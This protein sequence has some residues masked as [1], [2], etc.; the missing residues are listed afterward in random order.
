MRIK[1]I[2]FTFIFAISI[3]FVPA[4]V[5]DVYAGTAV[6]GT[7]RFN[8][9]VSDM[10]DCLDTGR[11]SQDGQAR[12]PQ[13]EW[14]GTFCASECPPPVPATLEQCMSTGAD[15]YECFC[16]GDGKNFFKIECTQER[17]D[18]CVNEVLGEV[19]RLIVI[20]EDTSDDDFMLNLECANLAFC[21]NNVREGSEV[22][23]GT[24]LALHDCAS[25]G[26]DGGTLACNTDCMSFDTSGCIDSQ[27]KNSTYLK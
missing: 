18:F 14:C 3:Y 10:T 17:F 22:C 25:E 1:Q 13:C 19:K 2:L 8:N 23:D 26:F 11:C 4:M 24:D 21:G 15:T 7:D 6:C 12:G 16:S 9:C 5:Q 27:Y 20:D